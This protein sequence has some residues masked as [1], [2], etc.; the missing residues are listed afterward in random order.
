MNEDVWSKIKCP[1]CQSDSGLQIIYGPPT[2][3]LF[4]HAQQGKIFL[5]GN[6]IGRNNRH[7]SDCGHDWT[8]TKTALFITEF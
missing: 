4:L 2:T 8:D 6:R 1:H 5:G 7:C 3:N